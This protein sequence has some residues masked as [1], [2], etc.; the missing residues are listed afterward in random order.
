M[1]FIFDMDCDEDCQRGQGED[2]RNCPNINESFSKSNDEK[3][4]FSSQISS[5][6]IEEFE[7]IL[8]GPNNALSEYES[9]PIEYEYLIQSKQK[10]T[11]DRNE[12]NNNK[13]KD[14]L[15]SMKGPEKC[16][17][18][19]ENEKKK[20]KEQKKNSCQIAKERTKCNSKENNNSSNEEIPCQFQKVPEKKE[21]ENR[22]LSPPIK[23]MNTILNY[24]I[25][26]KIKSEPQLL[27]DFFKGK[28]KS[29]GYFL[30]NK[31]FTQKKINQNGHKGKLIHKI[32]KFISS[33]KL[34]KF[35]KGS[36]FNRTML[37]V[38]QELYE[39]LYDH[40]DLLNDNEYFVKKNNLFKSVVKYPLV[41]LEYGD[42]KGEKVFGYLK[43]YGFKNEAE[44]Y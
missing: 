40:L 17:L 13:K 29:P 23:Y 41:N 9:K 42:G 10:N 7:N 16:E 31:D 24:Y 27:E 37:E 6:E 5:M 19:M 1:N 25:T 14:F 22:S 15:N 20:E 3:D 2:L 35:N 11:F 21:K 39:W 43:Y 12:K 33:K 18:N 34:D 32:S 36:L 38:F 30:I 4:S 26:G 44:F 28:K 8:I